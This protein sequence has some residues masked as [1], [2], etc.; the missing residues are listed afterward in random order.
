MNKL[1]STWIIT[2]LLCF[3]WS[4]APALTTGTAAGWNGSESFAEEFGE[5]SSGL[6]YATYGQTFVVPA[7]MPLL[8]R[9]SFWLADSPFFDP[10]AVTFKFRVFEWNTA[11]QCAQGAAIYA[12]AAANTSGLAHGEFREFRFESIGAVLDASRTYVATWSASEFLDGTPSAAL[13]GARSTNAYTTGS[14]VAIRNGSDTSQWT[15]QAWDVSPGSWDTAFEVEVS[16]V[17]EPSAAWLVLA[18]VALVFRRRRS[19]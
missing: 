15:N 18:G 12:S 5:N 9:F 16:S 3:T 6:A 10:Q 8:E 13:V 11:S 1:F 19:K 4:P 2:G 17:P 7:G 14:M